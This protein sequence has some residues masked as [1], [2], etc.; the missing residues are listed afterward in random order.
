M[1]ALIKH[2]VYLGIF[3]EQFKIV[4]SANTGFENKLVKLL[5][6]NKKWKK[7]IF[8]IDKIIRRIF[9]Y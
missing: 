6:N 4:L 2:E 1:E 5:I 7:N 8:F 9:R 3:P